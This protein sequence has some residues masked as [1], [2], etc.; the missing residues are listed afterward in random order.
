MLK[1]TIWAAAEAGDM[2]RKEEAKRHLCT[3]GCTALVVGCTRL[4]ALPDTLPAVPGAVAA[5]A[6]AAAAAVGMQRE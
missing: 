4:S 6:V 2:L 5:A 3:R 1:S